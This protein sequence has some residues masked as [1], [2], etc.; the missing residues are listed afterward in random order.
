MTAEQAIRSRAV[1]ML[2][3]GQ[4]LAIATDVDSVPGQVL[5]GIA[6]PS[7]CCVL[8]IGRS[9]YEAQGGWMKLAEV[10]GFGVRVESAMERAL[11]AIP[12]NSARANGKRTRA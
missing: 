8:T 7:H 2:K 9:E 11:A 10:A 1:A 6:R 4:D 5:V 12:G 3:P